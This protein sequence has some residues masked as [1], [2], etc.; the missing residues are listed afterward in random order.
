MPRTQGY[1]GNAASERLQSTPRKTIF[2]REEERPDYIEHEFEEQDLSFLEDRQKWQP[3]DRTQLERK[4]I[5]RQENR[6]QYPPAPNL[7]VWAARQQI[8]YLYKQDP[9]QW[10]PERLAESFPI[11]VEDAKRLVRSK[12]R[13]EPDADRIKRIDLQVRERW[14]ALKTGKG[15]DIVTSEQRKLFQEG[16]LSEVQAGVN[17]S[18]PLPPPP[19]E[20][21]KLPPPPIGPFT[22]MIK[23]YIEEQQ[24]TMARKQQIVASPERP[25]LLPLTD[26]VPEYNFMDSYR[27]HVPAIV[28]G[29][30]VVTVPEEEDIT[31]D[32]RVRVVTGGRPRSQRL[33]LHSTVTE[34][35]KQRAAAVH[36]EV[37][38]A[39]A[40]WFDKYETANPTR[41]TSRMILREQQTENVQIPPPVDTTG[42]KKYATKP[43]EKREKAAPVV[44]SEEE[45]SIPKELRQENAVYRKG[46]SFYDN[47]G[48]FLYRVPV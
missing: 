12:A 36:P 32:S 47:K 10:S 20:P 6:E 27:P 5:L 4:R 24:K 3:R 11:S 23:S 14:K 26:S 19:E 30:E 22:N 18:F 45:I 8:K 34:S 9:E 31:P 21:F 35:I 28:D 41:T 7:L 33:I 44:V 37:G 43:W 25:A 15:G 17:L 42:I 40:E 46:D 16:K 2:F 1:D 48:K 39:Y 13:F 29:F 38:R